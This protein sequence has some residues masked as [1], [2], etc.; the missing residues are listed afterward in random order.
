ML[1]RILAL[2]ACMVL[3]L[4]AGIWLG[5]HP[6]RLPSPV[7]KALV[8]K[9]VAIVGEGL[10]VLQRRYYRAPNE[11]EVADSALR[12]AVESL[13]DQFSSYLAPK[14]LARFNEVTGAKF[15]GIGVEIQK[16]R[17]GLKVVRV[18]AGSP[19]REAGLKAGDV[20]TK[21]A[22]KS[23]AGL[24]T[25]TASTFI[26]GPKGTTVELGIERDGKPRTEQV[27]RDEVRIPIVASH[28]DAALKVGI[29][30]LASFSEGATGSS[31]APST[32]CGSA[33]QRAS[34]SICAPTPAASLKRRS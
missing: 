13:D 9:D 29:V 3:A 18:Y 11:R 33:A 20:I 23:L 28:Y 26:R 17:K 8:Q 6:D 34:C 15:T 24:S 22:G 4:V 10:G 5:G 7:R 2:A 25:Q 21:A 27:R 14:D 19:A 16:D 32:S 31:S 30:R 12:A 1:R